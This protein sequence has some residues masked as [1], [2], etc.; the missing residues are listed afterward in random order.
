MSEMTV[1]ARIE[2]VK[3]KKVTKLQRKLIQ[4]MESN[5]Y[6]SIIYFSITEFAA[7]AGVAEA[8]VLRFCRSL[9]FNG[10]QDFKLSL[11]Q[12]IGPVHKK[13]DEKSYIYDIC[14]SYMEM[15]DRC[16]QR[17]SLDRVEQA[18]QC[19][20]SAKTICCFG[21]GNS[22]VP[23]LELHNRLMKMGICSQCERD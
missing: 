19:L 18:V 10:Y 9:G 16:R 12:E 2:K 23:A 21:V 7:A 13:I 22:Y 5:S 17:L 1:K 3:E 20:L 14:S 6:E 4:F 15:L 11:A 8:T